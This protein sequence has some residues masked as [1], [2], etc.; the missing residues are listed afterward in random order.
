MLCCGKGSNTV[1]TVEDELR[2]CLAAVAK[3]F[4]AVDHMCVLDA[5][6]N[7]LFKLDE[8]EDISMEFLLSSA[9]LVRSAGQFGS[10]SYI[11]VSFLIFFSDRHNL[12]ST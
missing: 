11:F 5:N 9:S 10:F 1:I 2:G 12:E 8:Q 6:G 3:N 4:E 7:L